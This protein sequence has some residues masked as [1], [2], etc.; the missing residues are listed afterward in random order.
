M[1]VISINIRRIY[2]KGDDGVVE[3]LLGLRKWHY[4]DGYGCEKHVVLRELW[5]ITSE[6]ETGMH[7]A[8]KLTIYYMM[9]TARWVTPKKQ[10]HIL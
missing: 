6:G 1:D 9:S 7:S 2:H 10:V 3:L 8:L 4:L 5:F